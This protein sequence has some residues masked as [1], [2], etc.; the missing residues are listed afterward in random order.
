LLNVKKDLKD[1]FEEV[2]KE[3]KKGE[4]A[5]RKEFSSLCGVISKQKQEVSHVKALITQSKGD[6]SLLDKI[7]SKVKGIESGLKNF[8][9]KSR[10]D[11]EGLVDEEQ[12][13]TNELEMW[14]EKFESYA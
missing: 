3:E 12:I 6:P 7:H 11:Y 8:K 14:A 5:I 10:G 4:L 9:L 2:E 1:Y 13:I